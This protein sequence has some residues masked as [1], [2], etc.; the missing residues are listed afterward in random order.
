MCWPRLWC[1]RVR[2]GSSF[3]SSVLQCLTFDIMIS[4][5]G[6]FWLHLPGIWT[7][8][9]LDPRNMHLV[10]HV[11]LAM[12][13]NDL[14]IKLCILMSQIGM[15]IHWNVFYPTLVTDDSLMIHWFIHPLMLNNGFTEL[16]WS[17]YKHMRGVNSFL[18]FISSSVNSFGVS[19]SAEPRFVFLGGV[20]APPLFGPFGTA[21]GRS[22]CGAALRGAEEQR[23]A[24]TVGQ[25][26]A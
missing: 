7:F 20:S 14:W 19:D 21:L 24:G 26:E 18:R 25:T 22:P 4:Q 9:E 5:N 23:T 8:V 1:I 6:P 13:K 15:M 10:L 17:S 2:C 3:G 12:T 16:F 11:G